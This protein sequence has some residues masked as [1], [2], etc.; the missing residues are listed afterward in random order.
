[1]GKG[2]ENVDWW[3]DVSLEHVSINIYL[4]FCDISSQIWNWMGNIVIEHCK[5]RNL[6]DGTN[7]TSD[8]TSSLIN[9]GKICIHVT[10]ITSS[11]WY[12]FSC[13]RDFSQ[14]VCIR[15]HISQ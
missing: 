13:C 1:M 11:T 10:W 14:S 2:W 9:S 12:F 4:T 15:C 6:C 3:I 5:N 7:F 8:S